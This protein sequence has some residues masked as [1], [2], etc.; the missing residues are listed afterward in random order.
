MTQLFI[1]ALKAMGYKVF[2][3][4][5]ELNI[6]GVR[7]TIPIVNTF[8]DSINVMYKDKNGNWQFHS[9]PATTDPGTYWLKNPSNPNGTAILKA[10]QYIDSHKM[11]MHRDRYMAL[12]QRGLLTVIRDAD[13]NGELNFKGKEDTGYFG[14]NIH[15]AKEEGTVKYIDKYSAGCQVFANGD[16][17]AMFMQMCEKHRMLYGNNFSYTL[18]NQEHIPKA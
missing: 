7:S 9:F 15:R 1:S 14:I 17:F 2:T 6:I 12:V 13:K 5:Y 16:D 8:S 18:I 3:R 10:G 11:D 4:P